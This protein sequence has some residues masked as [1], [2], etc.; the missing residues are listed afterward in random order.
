MYFVIQRTTDPMTGP[1][2][3]IANVLTS[4]RPGTSPPAET[5][6]D[7]TVAAGTT[8]YYRV[9]ATNAVGYMPL[10]PYSDPEAMGFPTVRADSAPSAVASATTP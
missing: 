2:E 3:T 8:Y 1:W 9:I 4:D 10:V 5:Y 7:T 6:T